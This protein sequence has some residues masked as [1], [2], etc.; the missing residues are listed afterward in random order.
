MA[1]TPLFSLPFNLETEVMHLGM[2]AGFTYVVLNGEGITIID[3][4]L[5]TEQVV[6]PESIIVD[7]VSYDVLAINHHAF[8]FNATLKEISLPDNLGYIGYGAFYETNKLVIV[9]I[10]E[11][12]KLESIDS[13]AFSYAHKLTSIYL[14]A[15]LTYLADYAFQSAQ[16]L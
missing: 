8:S 16:Q 9:N 2:E 6:I 11:T 4:D 1:V 3:Y 15:S 10:N 12:S 7:S 13:Y 14:P 5:E